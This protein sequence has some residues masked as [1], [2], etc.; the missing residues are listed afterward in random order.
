VVDDVVYGGRVAEG[1]VAGGEVTDGTVVGDT[2]VGNAVVGGSVR[3]ASVVGAVVRGVVVV[4]RPV[5]GETVV[6]GA[7]LFVAEPHAAASTTNPPSSTIPTMACCPM[8]VS[9]FTIC[10]PPPAALVAGC[11]ESRN[12]PQDRSLPPPSCRHLVLRQTHLSDRAN[13][14]HDAVGPEKCP[15]VPPGPITVFSP[16]A[17]R[18]GRPRPQ[19]SGGQGA[20][21]QPPERRLGRR[22][23]S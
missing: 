11:L 8:L 19:R 1:S 23:A 3:G 2:V 4:D 15:V 22:S 9:L 12:D 14:D 13:R 17:G 18:G 6:V 21:R 7:E 16:I 20:L 10:P 5:T